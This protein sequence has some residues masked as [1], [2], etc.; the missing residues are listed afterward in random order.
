MA[1]MRLRVAI[2]HFKSSGSG[3]NHDIPEHAIQGFNRSWLEIRRG[4]IIGSQSRVNNFYI[5]T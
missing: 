3:L 4:S 5:L 2:Q 1:T